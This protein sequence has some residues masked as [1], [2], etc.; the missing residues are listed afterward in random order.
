MRP[1]KAA[2]TPPS[3]WRKALPCGVAGPGEGVD[4]PAL[5]PGD[6]G[7]DVGGGAEAIKAQVLSLAGQLEATVTDETRA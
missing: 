1:E 2:R 6:L 3:Q 7:Q 4:L 5:V